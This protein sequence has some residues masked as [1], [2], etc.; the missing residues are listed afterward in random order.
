[1]EPSLPITQ[2]QAN[3]LKNE[4]LTFKKYWEDYIETLATDN[5]ATLY[6]LS[7][8]LGNFII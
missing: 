2:S 3:K 7:K 6:L 5:S 1:M 4:A 8:R